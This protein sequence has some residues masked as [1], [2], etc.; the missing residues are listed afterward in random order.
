VIGCVILLI[1][2][3]CGI[4]TRGIS[5]FCEIYE[6]VYTSA[7]DTEETRAQVDRNNAA[8]EDVCQK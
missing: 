5:S 1:V 3:G 2:S 6:P 8:Y 7:Q 4:N